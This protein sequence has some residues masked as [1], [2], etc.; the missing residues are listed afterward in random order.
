MTVMKKEWEAKSSGFDIKSAASRSEW[1]ELCE[2]AEKNKNN[3]D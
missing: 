1:I 3:S 2:N